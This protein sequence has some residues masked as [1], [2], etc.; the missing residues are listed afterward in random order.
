MFRKEPEVQILSPLPDKRMDDM[1]KISIIKATEKDVDVIL[2]MPNDT[3]F[4]TSMSEDTFWPKEIL[5]K[6]VLSDD[7]MFYLAEHETGEISGFIICGIVKSMEKLHIENVFV[8][9]EHRR[10]GI[11]EKL[12]ETILGEAKKENLRYVIG[13]TNDAND[14]FENVGFEKGYEFTW[15][16]LNLKR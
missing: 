12:M 16:D 1:E 15:Y 13:L 6:I 9:E 14:F 5:R 11:G 8:A 10:K 2:Q 3:V 4:A 7:A